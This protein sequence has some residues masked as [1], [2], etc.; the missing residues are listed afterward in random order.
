M[1]PRGTPRLPLRCLAPRPHRR[2]RSSM[3]YALLLSFLSE[4]LRPD[5]IAVLGTFVS[6]AEEENDRLLGLHEVDPVPWA[7]VDPHLAHAFADGLHIADVA[8]LHSQDARRD[9]GRCAPILEAL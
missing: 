5:D 1:P 7:V 2:A 6:A 8:V 4:F 3:P 9:T